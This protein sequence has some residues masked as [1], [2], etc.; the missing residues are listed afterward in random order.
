MMSFLTPKSSTA[1][2]KSALSKASIS[3]GLLMKT[4]LGSYSNMYDNTGPF[5]PVSLLLDMIE[6]TLKTLAISTNALMPSQYSG[7]VMSL[8]PS[9]K[10]VWWST[11]KKALLDD[12]SFS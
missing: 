3:P 2:L 8:I 7:S 4:A 6:G 12:E 5:G 9:A 10:P 1:F 11:N